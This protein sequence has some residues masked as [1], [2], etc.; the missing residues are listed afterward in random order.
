MG[1]MHLLPLDS[2]RGHFALHERLIAEKVAGVS[3]RFAPERR[4]LAL[5]DARKPS[6]RPDLAHRVP[7]SIVQSRAVG[8][9]LQA[10][11]HEKDEKEKEKEKEKDGSWGK[12]R[13]GG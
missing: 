5:E 10:C 12:D 7:G 6:L 1:G 13:R 2:L 9:C 8:L 4:D 3:K 11:R